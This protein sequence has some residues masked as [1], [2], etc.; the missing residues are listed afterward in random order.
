VEGGGGRARKF[1]WEWSEGA[2]GYSICTHVCA[3]LLHAGPSLITLQ[4]KP[5]GTYCG[6]VV[7]Q[8]CGVWV[9]CGWG[10]GGVRCVRVCMCVY[11]SNTH[12]HTQHTHTRCTFPAH[13]HAHTHTYT[14][15]CCSHTTHIHTHTWPS[16]DQ[17]STPRHTH[18]FDDSPKIGSAHA[19]THAHFHLFSQ[20]RTHTHTETQTHIHARIHTS[21]FASRR[22]PPPWNSAFSTRSQCD[23]KGMMRLGR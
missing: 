17:T 22:C 5:N 18:L 20:T 3:V 13:T 19:H 21:L 15:I 12:A 9:G 10:E 11:S 4:T 23:R 8:V 1:N 2:R 7:E 14:L 6:T 16:H